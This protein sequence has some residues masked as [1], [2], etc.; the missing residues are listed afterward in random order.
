MSTTKTTLPGNPELASSKE[1]LEKLAA[2]DTGNFKYQVEDYFAKPKA[3]SFNVSP[4]GKYISYLEKDDQGKRHVMVK[5]RET[6]EVK[7]AIAE[8]D[9]LIRGYG[10]V[11]NERLIYTMDKGGD[12]NYHLFA[13]NVDGGDARDLTPF[14]GAKASILKLLKEDKDHIIISMNK[15]NPSVFDP[16]KLNVVTGDLE[17]LYSND[18][19]AN[20]ITDYDFDKDGN[21]KAFTR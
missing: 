5:L 2:L 8:K 20:P 3:A 13:V 21:L 6:G 16:Y 14:K 11:N 19:E 18:D 7:R 4:D 1:D 9:E 12:E 17:Q 10:W 15:N